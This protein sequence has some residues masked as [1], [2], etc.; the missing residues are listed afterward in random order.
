M[1]TRGRA[2]HAGSTQ[3]I[4]NDECVRTI[5]AQGSH[6]GEPEEGEIVDISRRGDSPR[7]SPQSRRLTHD[8][9]SDHLSQRNPSVTGSLIEEE[10][11]RQS[12]I[13][14]R[15]SKGKEHAWDTSTSGDSHAS[16]RTSCSSA[17]HELCKAVDRI[18]DTLDG[19]QHDIAAMR[20]ARAYATK[21]ATAAE[22]AAS[23][24]GQQ[25][26]DIAMVVRLLQKSTKHRESR[27]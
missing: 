12:K 7:E 2:S 15:P 10:Q 8:H 11:R 19:N 16:T 5:S 25:L 23:N 18:G 9:R 27:H 24:M 3:D 4:I 13:V 14:P 1:M 6:G 22:H 20:D 21:M 17:Q 26:Q